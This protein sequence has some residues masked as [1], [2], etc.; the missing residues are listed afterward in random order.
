MTQVVNAKCAKAK[1]YVIAEC[2][3]TRFWIWL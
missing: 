2:F 1:S 3:S